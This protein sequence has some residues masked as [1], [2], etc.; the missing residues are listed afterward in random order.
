[1]YSN[2]NFRTHT[3]IINQKDFTALKARFKMTQLTLVLVIMLAMCF[4]SFAQN[5]IITGSII[6]KGN[7][8]RIVGA[9]VSLQGT[10]FVESTDS[11][12]QFT[13]N[14]AMP[15]QE[16]LIVISKDG[17]EEGYFLINPIKGKRLKVQDIALELTSQEKKRRKKLTKSTRKENEKQEKKLSKE[18]K[19]LQKD[20]KGPLGFLKKDKEVLAVTYEDIPEEKNEV[21]QSEPTITPL[22]R[23]YAQIIGTTPE[24]IT[25]TE[26]Y[27]FIDE[28][29]ET[30]YEYGGDSKSGIDCSSFSQRLFLKVYG[31]FIERT[32]QNQMDSEATETFSGMQFLQEG[33]LVFFRARGD[34]G[35]T[36]THVGIYLGE[37]KFV[38]ATPRRGNSKPGVKISDL[39]EPY[40]TNRFYAGGRRIIT[41]N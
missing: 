18:K 1:M 32:A 4:S 11:N 34:V 38:N 37:H 3:A 13:F 30:P 21:V 33:D 29:M 24:N 2:S 8:T 31:G 16:F 40:W 25:N 26:L 22:Q 36:I 14:E 19:K 35:D 15:Q 27:T 20:K 5:T 12:G 9:I 7:N 28:W 39:S 17:Y 10:A 6:E 41:K 23:K